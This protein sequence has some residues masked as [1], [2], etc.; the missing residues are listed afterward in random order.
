LLGR[1][2]LRARLRRR[3]QPAA[4]D[5]SQFLSLPA[6]QAAEDLTTAQQ[7]P[8]PPV[9]ATTLRLA[10]G[11]FITFLV[12]ISIEYQPPYN[13]WCSAGWVKRCAS[14][15]AAAGWGVGLSSNGNPDTPQA[16]NGILRAVTMGDTETSCSA[17]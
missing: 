6:P 11:I 2:K 5:G 14:R 16:N 17:C 1:L 3:W 15:A 8:A 13:T 7:P 9:L 4:M 12:G 10:I